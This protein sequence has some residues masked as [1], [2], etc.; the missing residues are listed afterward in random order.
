MSRDSQPHSPLS[1]KGGRTGAG[2][3]P[4]PYAGPSGAL[5]FAELFRDPRHLRSDLRLLR[6]AVR[7]RWPIPAEARVEL[8]ARMEAAVAFLLSPE[9]PGPGGMVT[10]RALV[11]LARALMAMI[12]ANRAGG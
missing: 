3:D 12:D 11:A 10:A 2:S 4:P 1:H 9:G 7:E 5:P 8:V 6:R